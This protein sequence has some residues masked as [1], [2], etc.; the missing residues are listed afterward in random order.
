MR[1][2]NTGSQKIFVYQAPMNYVALFYLLLL[3]WS[4]LS[5]FL[6]GGKGWLNWIQPFMVAFVFV[7]TWYFSLAISY[8][9]EINEIGE[10]ELISLRRRV[11]IPSKKIEMIEGPHLP[12]GFIR[13]RLEREKAYLF[14]IPRNKELQQ[15]LKIIQKT[16]P[17]IKFKN[18]TLLF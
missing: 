3:V 2:K 4:G 8:K 14:A 12:F 1:G 9:V 16:N 6:L 13:F 7:M 5:F 11:T 15:I 10:V 18:L 17:E